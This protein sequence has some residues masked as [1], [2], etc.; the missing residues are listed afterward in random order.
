MPD[1]RRIL[2]V[3]LSAM[4]DVLH[5]LPAVTYLRKAAP[6]AEID[7]AV[8]TRF[9]ELLEGNPGIAKVVP[10]PIREWKGRLGSPAT[11]R[12]ARNAAE[13][14]RGR[15]YDLAI[16]LQGNI[17]SGVVTYL[18][19]APLR[20]GFP[21]ETARE[22]QNLWFTNRQPPAVEGDRHVTQK[23]LRVASAP[24]GGEFRVD[25]LKGEITNTPE[26]I[27]AAERLL[28]D[29]FPGAAPRLAMH[30][31][32]TWNTKRMD[33]SFWA[34]TVQLLR[35]TFPSMGVFLSWGTEKEREECLAIRYMAGEGVVLLPRLGYK[36]LA[37]VYR[38]CGHMIGPDTGPLHLAA[39][40]GAKTVSVFRGSDGKYAAPVG[41]AHRF[42]QAPLPCT[43]CQIKGDKV[44]PRDAECRATIHPAE[45]A[46]AMAELMGGNENR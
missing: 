44:C 37:A 28:F 11:W 16:D 35:A 41:S 7:W 36:A 3:K 40:V 39:A 9:A 24:F 29:A 6:K 10:L 1:V 2:I 30:P 32:T 18:S 43:A 25:D 23:I 8:D 19:G 15:K 13:A 46:T 26:E 5:A 27:A 12:E 45:V 17:K 34:E 20:Y 14:L 4:G 38:A 31:G 21:R 42:L 33:P 22:R